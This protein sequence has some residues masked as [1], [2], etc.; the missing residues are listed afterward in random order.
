MK[1]D[2]I[3]FATDGKGLTST[4]ANHIAN[5]AKEM[6]RNIETSL[7]DIVLYT[8]NVALIGNKNVNILNCGASEAD[9][10]LI[11]DKLHQT[12]SAKSL[13]AWLREAIKAKERL[14]DEANNL[15]LEEY[16]MSQSIELEK[17]PEIATILTEDEYFAAKPVD[18]RCHY[19]ELETL[20]ATLGQSHSSRRS[21]C[22]CT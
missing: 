7:D 13:I 21:I 6:I 18:E 3:F 10:N 2:M 12:A 9:V 15:T 22:R 20:A 19:Y 1:K 14:L 8:T 5:L 17:Q 16:A 4:S 11:A